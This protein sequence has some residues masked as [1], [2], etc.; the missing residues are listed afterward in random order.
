MPVQIVRCCAPGT[1]N[2]NFAMAGEPVSALS[3][4]VILVTPV[5]LVSCVT[6][7]TTIIAMCVC[8]VWL[9]PRA[10]IEGLVPLMVNANVLRAMLAMIVRSVMLAITKSVQNVSIA[11]T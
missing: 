11:T 6:T 2:T 8:I 7:I 1:N 5:M 10:K 4:I 3:A 9:L